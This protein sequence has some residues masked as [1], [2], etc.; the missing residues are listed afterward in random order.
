M[1]EVFFT[2]PGHD[3]LLGLPDDLQQRIKSK[4]RDV[5]NDP[6]RLPKALRGYDL[7]VPRVGDHRVILDWDRNEG[8]VY[9]HAIGHRRNV[10]D[11]DL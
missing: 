3:D 8:A 9:V 5:R 6:A 7:H 1:A 4:L 2:E 11:R 10:Y